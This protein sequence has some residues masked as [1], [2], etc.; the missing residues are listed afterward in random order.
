MESV[1]RQMFVARKENVLINVAESVKP[2]R[3]SAAKMVCAQIV[4]MESAKRQRH[5]MKTAVVKGHAW[6]SAPRRKFVKMADAW[7]HA[8]E[9]VLRA[10]CVKRKDA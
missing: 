5:A 1:K 9:N 10:R 2:R 7:T 6:A 4:A 3:E 8:V